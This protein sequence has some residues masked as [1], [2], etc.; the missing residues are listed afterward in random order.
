MFEPVEAANAQVRVRLESMRAYNR[1]RSRY[2]Q[3][4]PGCLARICLEASAGGRAARKSR[5]ANPRIGARDLMPY[6][7]AEI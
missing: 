1:L 3:E 2:I 5:H 4:M 6:A 7:S